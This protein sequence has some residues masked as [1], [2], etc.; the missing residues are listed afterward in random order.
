MGV[1]CGTM[2][3]YKMVHFCEARLI[4]YSIDVQYGKCHFIDYIY[5]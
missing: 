4:E 3:F 5:I 2:G 1:I